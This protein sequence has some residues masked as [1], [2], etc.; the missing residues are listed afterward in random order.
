MSDPIPNFTPG[1]VAASYQL[2]FHFGWYAHG[3]QPLFADS[4]VRAAIERSFLRVAKDRDYHVLEFDLESK[5]LR[6]LV[7]LK[8]GDTPAEVTRVI[9]GNIATDVRREAGLRNLWSRGW[10]VRSVGNVSN[11]VMRNYVANQFAHHRAAPM[12]A[13]ESIA[14]ARFHDQRDPAELRKTAHAA[15]EYNLHLVLVVRRR[16]EF[17]DMKVAAVLLDYLRAVCEKKRWM[18]WDIEVVWNHVHLF[19][20]VEPVDA[21]QAVALSVMNNAAF[22]LEQKY[23]AALKDEHLEGVW[24]PGYHAGTVGAATT[25]QV[26]AFLRSE[27]ERGDVE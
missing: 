1:N 19:L 25:A 10:F 8:P 11:D 9:K 12:E 13:P 20:G 7:S 16:F 18:A 3:R 4:A 27:A 17:L 22:F 26:K 6:A 5:V 2:R 14:L 23:G 24:Q 15:F 21:P